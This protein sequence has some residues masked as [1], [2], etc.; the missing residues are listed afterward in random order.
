MVGEEIVPTIDDLIKT[1]PNLKEF[2]PFLDLLNRESDRGKVLIS[3]GFMEEQLKQVL[4]AFFREDKASTELVDG[5]NAALGSFSSRIAACYALGLIGQVEHHDL[6]LI[7]KIRNDFAHHIHTNFATASVT[8]RCKGLMLRAPDDAF[9]AGDDLAKKASGQ[10][11]TAAVG[12][13]LRLVN[14]PHYVSKQRRAE[15]EWP[16]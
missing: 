15:Q 16:H 8:D 6:T 12:L 14:R 13:I 7:R 5:G 9:N 2:I 4:L 10:F 1:H 11:Q 3:T